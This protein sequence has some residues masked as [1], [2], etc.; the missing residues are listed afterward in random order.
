[1]GMIFSI[2]GSLTGVYSLLLV[3]R[4]FLSWF[5]GPAYGKPVELLYRVTDPCLNL[6]R[7]FPLHLANFDLTPIAALGFLQILQSVFGTL[8]RG[9]RVT[10]GFI[11]SMLLGIAGSVVSFI[12]VFCLILLVLRGIAYFT[13]RNI[14]SPFWSVIDSLAKPVQYRIGRFLFG[15]RI[16][17]YTTELFIS[18]ALLLVLRIALGF[19]VNFC[20]RLLLGLPF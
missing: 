20:S 18:A 3:I 11:L 9:G 13:N 19:V 6:F 17:H 16:V 8:A 12:L 10:V 15:R 1:M 14:Y 5:Q 4:V 7:R 2:L